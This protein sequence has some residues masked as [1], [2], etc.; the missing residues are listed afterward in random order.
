MCWYGPETFIVRVEGDGTVP[1]IRD[2][3]HVHVDPDEPAVDGCFVGVRAI[4]GGYA[5]I[6][7][8]SH[9]NGRR[10]LGTL[11]PRR[12]ECALDEDNETMIRGVAV[13]VGSA[14]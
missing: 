10:A 8:L 2:G 3:G 6:R 4:V 13:Y 5:T 9:E 12:I 7:R 11:N 14:V 1:R